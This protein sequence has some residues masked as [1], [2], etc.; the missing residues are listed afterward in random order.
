[1]TGRYAGHRPAGARIC[2]WAGKPA[3]D[4]GKPRPGRRAGSPRSGA[5]RPQT[6]EAE[7]PAPAGR[8]AGVQDTGSTPVQYTVPAQAPLTVVVAVAEPVS[9]V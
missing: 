9:A 5:G 8:A 6:A 4:A 7:R 3:P 1:M 2:A